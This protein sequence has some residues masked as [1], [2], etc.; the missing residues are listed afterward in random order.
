MPEENATNEDLPAE[1]VSAMKAVDEAPLVITAGIDRNLADMASVHFRA[2]RSSWVRQGGWAALAACVALIAVLAVQLGGP[3][4][5]DE[6]SLYTDV[7]GSGRIDIADV[8]ALARAD[9]ADVTQ[10]DL[11]AFAMR[12]VAL[13]AGGRR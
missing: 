3:M 12:V 1:L 6:R 7:D 4:I 11:D 10:A 2:R 5:R 8:L 13:D 9:R